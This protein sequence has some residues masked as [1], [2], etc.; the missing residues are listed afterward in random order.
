MLMLRWFFKSIEEVI[1]KI[2][3]YNKRRMEDNLG[4]KKIIIA[5]MDIEKF[6]NNIISGKSSKIIR[7]MWEESELII[8]EIDN[9]KVGIHLTKE[10]II[11]FEEL[12]YI[13]IS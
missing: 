12:V 3:T 13:E 5:S 1:N 10:K 6:Y 8:E 11:E 9:D 4:D 2:E 7:K